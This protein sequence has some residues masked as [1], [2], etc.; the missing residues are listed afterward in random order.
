[1]SWYVHISM[2]VELYGCAN[3]PWAFHENFNQEKIEKTAGQV[4]AEILY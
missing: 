1:M 2:R 3:E 4:L